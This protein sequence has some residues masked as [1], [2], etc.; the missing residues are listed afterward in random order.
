MRKDDKTIT[1]AFKT[2]YSFAG[3]NTKNEVEQKVYRR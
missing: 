1:F 2:D 3:Q